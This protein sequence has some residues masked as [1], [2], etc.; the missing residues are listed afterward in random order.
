MNKPTPY[1]DTDYH[2]NRA[3]DV[4]KYHLDTN[5][6]KSDIK[7]RDKVPNIDGTLELVDDENHPI[8][9][10]DVQIRKI[11]EG[12]TK[13]PCPSSLVA[14][15]ARAILPV[16]LI[17]VD[18]KNEKIFW[19]HIF[20]SM[21]EYKADQASFTIHFNSKFDVIDKTGL[22]INRWENLLRDYQ[23]RIA[24]YPI[25]KQRLKLNLEL[26]SIQPDEIAFFQQYIDAIN[27]VLDVQFPN[28]KRIVFSGIWK[29][30][31]GI[32]NGQKEHILYLIHKI[33]FGATT[34]VIT[35]LDEE[36]INLFGESSNVHNIALTETSKENLFSKDAIYEGRKFALKIVQDAIKN[37]V[38]RIFGKYTASEQLFWF[39]DHYHFCLGLKE[40]D[41]YSL[42][43]LIHAFH[44]YLPFWFTEATEELSDSENKFIMFD[45]LDDIRWDEKKII[46]ITSRMEEKI[47]GGASVPR[48][49]LASDKINV[50]SIYQSLEY[51]QYNNIS[52]VHR[53]YAKRAPIGG[54]IW[55]GYTEAELEQRIQLIL[56]ESIFE[57]DEFVKGNNIKFERGSLFVDNRA[58]IYTYSRSQSPFGN[59]FFVERCIVDNSD[60]TLD[61]VIIL[62]ENQFKK[63]LS[64]GE[65]IIKLGGKKYNYLRCEHG[66]AELFDEFPFLDTL[67][68]MLWS[69]LELN[70]GMQE[71]FDPEPISE[72]N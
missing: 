61:R 58:M 34:P 9:K 53:P 56:R 26:D 12:V 45:T 23:E 40:A 65:S 35:K 5:R 3:V 66:V 39:I 11:P 16:L 13:Y 52:E 69:D 70:Y 18:I 14:Y 68:S 2:E 31:I 28:V 36:E 37:R 50:R 10:F 17:C 33:P 4:L 60:Q 38:F 29:L 57:Y 64:R 49:L 30:G 21:A 46:K 47:S 63:N 72:N 1:P 62:T 44:V 24:N 15:S 42:P 43:D 20:T 51:L 48:I 25:L 41:V 67:Y 19:R 8:G 71:H 55:D 6:I 7:T 27:F 54:W 22:Y 32:G 59:P